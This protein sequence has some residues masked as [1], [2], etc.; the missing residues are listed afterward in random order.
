MGS[1]AESQRVSE[2]NFHKSWWLLDKHRWGWNKE[3]TV[4]KCNLIYIFM[5]NG[6][7]S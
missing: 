2:Q 1:T 4:E 7:D 3:S 5:W 6:E